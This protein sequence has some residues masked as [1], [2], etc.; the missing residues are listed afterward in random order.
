MFKC[1]HLDRLFV[2]H[3]TNWRTFK[4]VKNG[5]TP[6]DQAV[7]YNNK[8]TIVNV[9]RENAMY[10]VRTRNITASQAVVVRAPC[11]LLS[12]THSYRSLFCP[13]ALM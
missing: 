8:A 10:Q 11:G 2:G 9:R 5:P 3:A 13:N 1:S 7:Y 6:T 12:L 4:S